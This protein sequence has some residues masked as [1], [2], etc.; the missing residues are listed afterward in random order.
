MYRPPAFREDRIDVLVDLAMHSQGGRMLLF[1]RKPAPVQIT[2]LAYCSTTGL[3]T[4]DYRLTDPYFDPPD[5]D[6]AC[7]TERSIRLPETYWCYPVP[8]TAPE[9]GAL[10]AR[11]AGHITFGCL[12]NSVK[13]NA[14]VI[15]T[16]AAILHAVQDS[17]I[18]LHSPEGS[19]RMRMIESLERL[20]VDRARI[21]F[22]GRVPM[23]KYFEAYQR[24][25]IALDPFPFAGGT[26]TCDALWMGVPVASLAGR[27]AVS[28]AGF[29]VLS[30]IGAGEW[31]VRIPEQYIQVA[32][33]L[34]ADL[35]RLQGLRST[36]RGRMRRSPL[37]DAPRFARNVEAAFRRAWREWVTA[38]AASA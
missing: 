16:W 32:I 15:D 37:M 10:P 26:T 30:N 11:S 38:R 12:N 7:Y 25:D 1:A 29:S 13:V 2:Y 4:M 31:V 22:V 33:Q 35:S 27:T 34:A 23:P 28:R 3:D 14:R 36:L 21:E 6:D 9:P 19:H 20:G 5:G 18:L 8:E 17:R 24:I